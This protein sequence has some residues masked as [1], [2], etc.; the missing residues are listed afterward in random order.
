MQN[1]WHPSPGSVPGW[2]CCHWR[3]SHV[4]FLYVRSPHIKSTN[5]FYKNLNKTLNSIINHLPVPFRC[6]QGP[7]EDNNRNMS[8]NLCRSCD[9]EKLVALVTIS[10]TAKGTLCQHCN[11][12]TRVTCSQ[13][14]YH[15]GTRLN[16]LNVCHGFT[17]E[18]GSRECGFLE[19]LRGFFYS[20]SYVITESK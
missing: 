3:F 13:Q 9:I 12:E 19:L 10:S 11:S 16:R 15:G 20:L 4:H 2:H 7:L 6:I 1:K 8:W 14:W 17:R 5:C 18:V